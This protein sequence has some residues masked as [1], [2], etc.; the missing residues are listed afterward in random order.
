MSSELTGVE[1]VVD[2][3]QTEPS[4]QGIS[5]DHESVVRSLTEQDVR[6]PPQ[7]AG[8]R[9]FQSSF[10]TEAPWPANGQQ[11]AGYHQPKPMP[12]RPKGRFLVGSIL[13]TIVGLIFFAIWDA[14]LGVVAYGVVTG[15]TLRVCAPFDGVITQLVVE[16]GDYVQQGD[17]LAYVKSPALERQLS[18]LRDELLEAEARLQSESARLKWES[19][20]HAAEYFELWGSLLRN[21]EELTRMQRDLARINR[22][23]DPLIIPAQEMDAMNFSAA[24]Q[25]AMVKKLE[26]ALIELRKRAELDSDA[27]ANEELLQLRPTLVRME[28]LRSSIRRLEEN[29]E[30]GRLVSPVTGLVAR[31]EHPDGQQVALMEVLVEVVDAGSLKTKLFVQQ[32]DSRGVQPGTEFGVRIDPLKTPV[33]CQ[34]VASSERF[35]P[36]PLSIQRYYRSDEPLLPVILK[37]E[38]SDADRREVRLGAVTQLQL[39][40]QWKETVTGWIKDDDAGTQVDQETRTAKQIADSWTR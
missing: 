24:G 30:E 26:D 10:S 28:S 13:A 2:H 20:T 37:M 9:G 17:V 33:R 21:R 6:Q 18:Q 39:L 4:G 34:V 27:T 16:E 15:D 5:I 35:E 32:N 22:L 11:S 40:S 29:L 23:K 14:F 3:L 8:P 38:L 31:C 1:K 12:K 25:M 19:Q 36:A 7:T